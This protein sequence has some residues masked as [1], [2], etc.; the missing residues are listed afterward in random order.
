MSKIS[1]IF[2]SDTGNTEAMAN[3]IGEGIVAAGKEAEVLN[4]S[5]ADV[6]A[7]KDA[8]VFALGSPATGSEEIE[9]GEMEPFVQEIEKF[10]KDKV[11]GLFGSHDWG[12]GQWMRDWEDRMK[13]AGATVLGDEGLI[14]NLTPEDDD[15]EKCKEFGKKL[16]EI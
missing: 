10:A 13:E 8:K 1:V 14:C 4:V 3:A 11:I 12:D 7:L 5:D 15:L 16:A 9:S 2:W 6:E